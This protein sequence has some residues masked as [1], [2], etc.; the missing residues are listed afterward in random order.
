MKVEEGSPKDMVFW[1]TFPCNE[2]TK[3]KGRTATAILQTSET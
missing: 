2:K 3:Q 1:G